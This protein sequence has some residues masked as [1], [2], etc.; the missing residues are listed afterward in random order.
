MTIFLLVII[1]I[2]VLVTMICSIITTIIEVNDKNKGKLVK[3][4]LTITGIVLVVLIV[5][6]GSIW[7]SNVKQTDKGK[8]SSENESY[9]L[10]EAGFNSVTLDE[11]LQLIKSEEK[12]VILIARPTCYYCE[13]FTPV[14]KQASEE[15]GVTVNYINTDKFSDDDWT[16]FNS[17]LD[18]LNTEEWGTPLTLVVQNGKVID[19]NNGY[20]ELDTIKE[21]FTSNGF[22]E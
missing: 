6:A 1:A 20:V 22:G 19:E 13:Q 4:A 8:T 3:K 17:S 5:V 15:L 2:M 9:A 18:Y 16:T 10:E 11:Y 14:L 12:N 21:F 7:I